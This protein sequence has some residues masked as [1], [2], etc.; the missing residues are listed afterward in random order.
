V[1][2]GQTEDLTLTVSNAGTAA[3]NVS[4]TAVS[5]AGFSLVPPLSS[6]TLQPGGIQSIT[7]RYTPASAASDS[8]TLT[9]A[10]NDAASPATVTLS[11][12]GVAGS[13]PTPGTVAVSDSFNRADATACALGKADLSLGGS[14]SHYYLPINST[15]GVSI[16]SGTLQNNTLDYAGVQL[17]A[18]SSCGGRGETLLQDLYMRV[19]LLVPASAAGVVQAGPYFRS[20][21]AAPG[22]GI[23]GG[24]SAGYWV[25]LT[26]TG[27]VRLRGL[28]P[29]AVIATTGIP[30][31]FDAAAFHTLETVA[32]GASL[33]VWLDG[34]GLT[35]TQDGNAVTSLA[36]PATGGSNDGTAG[37]AFADED[38]RGKAG[39]QKARNLAIAQPGS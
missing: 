18:A 25:T 15:T 14:G 32:Q 21:A 29:N 10:S 19:D 36:L 6:F 27:E 26:S 22:D 28:N 20:R 5:G 35:F 13:G 17:T 34:A 9:I 8:G 30:A 23:I 39:G 7:V 4:S 3:L 33:Q 24:T 1:T 12:T 11:G 2:V 31:S 37:I 16:V 38:N